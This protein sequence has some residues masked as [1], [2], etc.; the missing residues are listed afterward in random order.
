LREKEASK[1]KVNELIDFAADPND[2][3]GEIS[4][5]WAVK[6]NSDQFPTSLKCDEI[7]IGLH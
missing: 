3:F 5:I 1:T 2:N 7:I 4:V 6:L